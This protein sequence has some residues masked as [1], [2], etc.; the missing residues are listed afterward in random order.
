M[1]IRNPFKILDKN[2]LQ[3]A[4]TGVVDHGMGEAYEV[5]EF[6]RDNID[7][8]FT[9]AAMADEILLV[10]SNIQ[11]LGDYAL[12]THDHEGVYSKIGHIHPE[13]AFA[14]HNHDGVYQ[15]LGDYAPAEHLHAEYALSAEKGIAN[16]YAPLDDQGFL[17]VAHLPALS[18]SKPNVVTSETEQLAL[19]AESGDVAIRTDLQKNFIHNGGSTG[20]MSDWTEMAGAVN[21]VTSVNGQ[22]GIVVLG[23][24]DVGLGNVDNTSDA[25]KPVST[26]M[27]AALNTKI[28]EAP[29]DGKYYTRKDSA[30]V[31][32]PVQTGGGGGGSGIP[33]A[34]SDG[35]LYGRKDGAWVEITGGGGDGGG[36]TARVSARYWRLRALQENGTG[37]LAVGEV[38]FKD[39]GG[40]NIAT[41]GTPVAS[42][43]FDG[44]Y[45]AAKAFDG[46][47][48]GDN[49]WYAANSRRVGEWLGYDFGS[50]V[51]VHSIEIFPYSSILTDN[52]QGFV[53]EYSDDG[54]IWKDICAY[55]TAAWVAGAGQTFDI[56]LAFV[57]GSS[58]GGG[59]HESSENGT[60][61]SPQEE[62]DGSSNSSYATKGLQA[63]F[64]RDRTCSKI[65]AFMTPAS[66]AEYQACVVEMDAS[67][68]VTAVLAQ[69]SVISGLP[70]TQGVYEFSF[71]KCIISAGVRTAF[72]IVRV[73]GTGSS[74]V[75]MDYTGGGTMAANVGAAN[76][77]SIRAT[78][79]AIAV[80]TSLSTDSGSTYL[81]CP[82]VI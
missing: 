23:K 49:G 78:V 45:T 29:A 50:A 15:P 26:A 13:Y 21:T 37:D 65:V 44:T 4:A 43:N 9:V 57:G 66:G 81:A 1:A 14:N 41:G 61:L 36:A 47:T 40:S 5:V 68:N 19:T 74:P 77:G 3:P 58:G 60:I 48:T 35:T 75:T 64:S 2:K 73:D 59:T 51:A 54:V 62:H 24:A 39:S 55:K 10:A 12:K 11:R 22:Q 34:P 80:G 25:D 7:R 76:V 46:V 52:F 17:P 6:V 32:M 38:R 16:G 8:I 18:I 63:T 20:T 56:P 30:W 27:Q 79:S 67:Y 31:E 82:E 71:P 69:S 28:P 53:V 42:S 72:L 33:D 70:T